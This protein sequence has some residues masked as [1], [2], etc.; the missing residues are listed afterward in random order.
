MHSFTNPRESKIPLA[1]GFVVGLVVLS[2]CIWLFPQND[3]RTSLGMIF[4]AVVFLPVAWVSLVR[5]AQLLG[6]V[7]DPDVWR[8]WREE[9]LEIPDAPAPPETSRPDPG[10]PMSKAPFRRSRLVRRCR[11]PAQK[12]TRRA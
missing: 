8:D 5:L 6:L 2:F 12:L 7:R 10:R 9:P 4:C 11:K 1:I 3:A